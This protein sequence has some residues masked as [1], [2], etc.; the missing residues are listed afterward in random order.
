MAT[1]KQLKKLQEKKKIKPEVNDTNEL[2]RLIKIIIVILLVCGVFYFLNYLI[3]N[4]SKKP[5]EEEVTIQYTEVLM[6]D[7]YKQ[8]GSS[9][10]VL[11]RKEEDAYVDLYKSYFNY[12]KG[13]L[14]LYTANLD[15]AFNGTFKAEKTNISSDL[16]KLQLSETTLLLIKDKKIQASYV[17][18][19]KIQ[20]YL[21]N[22]IK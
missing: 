3:E 11:V 2:Q 6:A 15:D 19:D 20:T 21:K 14:K 12:Y 7:L 22:L 8:S 13:G 17:G 18:K 1:K 16:T 10:Y 9:Y 5:V 4:K